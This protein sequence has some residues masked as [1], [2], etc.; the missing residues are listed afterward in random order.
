MRGA[1]LVIWIFTAFVLGSHCVE[2]ADDTS[3][4]DTDPTSTPLFDEYDMTTSAVEETPPPLT[5]RAPENMTPPP[6][7][8]P[9]NHSTPYSRSVRT[10][11]SSAFNETVTS[12]SK[13][14]VNPSPTSTG[15]YNARASIFKLTASGAV[16]IVCILATFCGWAVNAL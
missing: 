14:P 3:L 8:Y 2:L 16:L 5:T 11:N 13:V 12:S 15:A 9:D 1:V 7:N 10:D 6:L 4:L